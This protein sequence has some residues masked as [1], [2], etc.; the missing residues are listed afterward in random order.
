ML[1]KVSFLKSTAPI[2]CL[3]YFTE[4]SGTVSSFNFAQDIDETS[5]PPGDFNIKIYYSYLNYS[6]CR[7]RMKMT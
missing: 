6:I 2:G 4:T 1:F 7:V 3:Q 5:A